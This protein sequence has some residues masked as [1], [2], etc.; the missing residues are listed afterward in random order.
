MQE[1][2]NYKLQLP[3]KISLKEELLCDLRVNPFTVQFY[4]EK[5]E[6]NGVSSVLLVGLPIINVV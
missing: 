5:T 4:S 2:Q 6:L 1:I 3:S